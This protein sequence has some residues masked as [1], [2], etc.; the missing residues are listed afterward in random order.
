MKLHRLVILMRTDTERLDWLEANEGQIVQETTAKTGQP[1]RFAV[2]CTGIGY[3]ELLWRVT[4]RE[5]IDAMID[6]YNTE[7]NHGEADSPKST[8]TK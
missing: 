3:G 1:F 7:S 6:S 4:I 8:T 2:D 5:A